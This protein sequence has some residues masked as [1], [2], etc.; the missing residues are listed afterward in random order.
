MNVKAPFLRPRAEAAGRGLTGE[1]GHP[2][3]VARHPAGVRHG[4]EVPAHGDGILRGR[5]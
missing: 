5:R 1:E 3:A 4:A 2:E